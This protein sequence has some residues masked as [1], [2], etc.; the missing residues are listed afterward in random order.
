MKRFQDIAVVALGICILFSTV[1]AGETGTIKI[2]CNK[3]V[4][5][6]LDDD[7]YGISTK[8]AQPILITEV[9][10]GEHVLVAHQKHCKSIVEKL[11]ITAGDTLSLSL[12]FKKGNS[13][14]RDEMYR[15]YESMKNSRIKN[16]VVPYKKKI[17][18][19]AINPENPPENDIETKPVEEI[20]ETL[21][22]ENKDKDQNLEYPGPE[23]FIAVDI[24]PEMVEMA[25]LEYPIKARNKKIT[26]TVWVKA[27]IDIDGIPVKCMVGKSSG[28]EILDKAAIKS[29]LSNKF[30]PG[31]K[32]G[33]PVAVW[34]T[35]KANF[36]L[37]N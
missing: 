35:Y 17:D 20:T 16:P 7:F 29:G 10:I 26:G 19:S 5:L 8:K 31:L 28:H 27:L 25:E 14:L 4:Y 24:M 34:I 2:E 33:D 3:D 6:L 32:D 11:E 1:R 23:E 36:I 30:K 15:Q 12:E 37:N 22:I 18:I 9:P 21:V 13:Y